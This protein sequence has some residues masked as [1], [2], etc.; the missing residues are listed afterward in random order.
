MK[1]RREENGKRERTKERR[2]GAKWERER[3][4]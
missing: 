4:G 2:E 1:S 3:C